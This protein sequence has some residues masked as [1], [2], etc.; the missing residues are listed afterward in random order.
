MLKRVS[1]AFWNRTLDMR[2]QTRCSSTNEAIVTSG[3]G[4]RL[5]SGGRIS[6][7]F[8]RTPLPWFSVNA[9]WDERGPDGVL[10]RKGGGPCRSSMK[11]RVSKKPSVHDR[12]TWRRAVAVALHGTC[13]VWAS[14]GIHELRQR[15]VARHRYR[16]RPDKEVASRAFLQP[17]SFPVPPFVAVIAFVVL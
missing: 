10:K 3:G 4:N 14:R 5:V 9:R 1:L 13:D 2:E 8:R 16:M 7:G 12:I 17:S 11:K 15:L 6:L